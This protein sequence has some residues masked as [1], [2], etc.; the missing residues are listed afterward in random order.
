MISYVYYLQILA[1]TSST[2]STLI[3]RQRPRKPI[4]LPHLGPWSAWI[5][6][7]CNWRRMRVRGET[8]LRSTP[9]MDT[10]GTAQPTASWTRQVLPD[11]REN[12]SRTEVQAVTLPQ[13]VGVR[14]LQP[15]RYQLWGGGKTVVK[16]TMDRK[17]CHV[18]PASQ[19]DTTAHIH[20]SKWE[21]NYCS[22]N[23]L[24]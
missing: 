2:V 17:C 3:S 6:A 24:M 1:T 15:Q 18:L 21:G 11:P 8:V 22:V 19:E 10:N 16:T 7:V 20:G 14:Y 9:E 13:I 4:K 12:S 5:C 23:G